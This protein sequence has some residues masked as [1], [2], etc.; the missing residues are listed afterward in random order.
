MAMKLKPLVVL[1]PLFAICGCNHK[2][3][4]SVAEVEHLIQHN[5]KPGDPDAKV[6]ALLNQSD[7]PYSFNEFEL[8]YESHVPKSRATDFKGMKSVI[9]IDIYVNEDRSFKR[10]EVRKVFTYL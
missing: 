6:I 8:R 9:G 5:L 10:A 4:P 2:G 3:V 1:I 7:F